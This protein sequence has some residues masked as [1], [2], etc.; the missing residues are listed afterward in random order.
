MADFIDCGVVGE[1]AARRRHERRR[2][3]SGRPM[4]SLSATGGRLVGSQGEGALR[5]NMDC[6]SHSRNENVGRLMLIGGSLRGKWRI[7]LENGNLCS[8]VLVAAG[9]F[10]PIYG[11]LV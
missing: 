1:P 8:L 11:R 5:V 2:L 10:I 9:I 6:N 7:Q 3:P 4:I